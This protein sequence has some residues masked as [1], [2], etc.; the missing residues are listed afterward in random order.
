MKNETNKEIGLVSRSGICVDGDIRLRYD[1]PRTAGANL[2]V[3]IIIAFIAT[4]STAAMAD[5][6]VNA[7]NG[8]LTLFFLT[9]VSVI[10]IS[11]TASRYLVVRISAVIVF[12][13]HA[14]NILLNLSNARIGFDL[15]VYNYL[16]KANIP[17]GTWGTYAATADT[18]DPKYMFQLFALV[19]LIVAGG[20]ALACVAKTDFPIL[21][22]FTFPLFEIGLYQGFE[23][24]T[25]STLGLVCCWIVQL[26]LH[27]INHTTNK[28]GRRNTFAVHERSRTFYFT[29]KNEKAKFFPLYAASV[30]STCVAL[31][32]VLLIFSA[33]TGFIRPKSFDKLRVNLHNAI[34]RLDITNL[35][36]FLS[37]LSGGDTLHGQKTIGGTNGGHLGENNGISFNGSVCLNVTTPAFDGPLYL[38]G[39]VGSIYKNNSW[40]HISADDFPGTLYDAFED[41][42]YIPQDIDYMLM[43]Q[44]SLTAWQRQGIY[45][46]VK[47]A[48]RKF[49]YA[50]YYASY[51]DFGPGDSDYSIIGDGYVY[52]MNKDDN[53]TFSYYSL[54]ETGAETWID[55]E[56]ALLSTKEYY[57][58]SGQIYGDYSAYGNRLFSDYSDYVRRSYLGVKQGLP[59]LDEAYQEISR[60]VEGRSGNYTVVYNAIKDYFDENGFTYTTTPGAT[61]KGEDFINYFLGTQKKGYCSYY[62][63]AGVMLLRMFGFPARYT[64]G[65]MILPSQMDPEQMSG[66]YYDIRVSD[67]CA[68]AWAEVYLDGIGWVPAEFT[69][70]Y[71]SNNNPHL[72]EEEK[73]GE[74]KKTETTTT[75]TAA[76]KPDTGDGSKTETKATDGSGKATTKSTGGNGGGN[77][78]TTTTGTGGGSDGSGTGTGKTTQTTTTKTGAP[79]RG[80]K[81][82]PRWLKSALLTFAAMVIVLLILILNRSRRLAVKAKKCSQKDLDKRVMEIYRYT[83]R[84]IALLGVEVKRNITDLQNCEELIRKCHEKGIK[85]I[86]EH[87][88]SLTDIAVKAHMSGDRVTPEEAASA[89]ASMR[90]ISKKVV[91]PALS[92]LKKLSAMLLH[93]LY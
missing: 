38:R 67:R 71:V 14:V 48:D 11:L 58:G 81:H 6:F 57:S 64:E 69:P 46:E 24:P 54:S 44:S 41:A 13:I 39:Y 49:I 78:K 52:P 36:E 16:E 20:A 76:K 21:F 80:V 84:Y 66:G 70:G 50:P 55:K 37:D 65:Y 2:P 53:Y 12:L 42:G 79:I 5:S 25:W 59:A 92:P 19:I 35:D 40:V 32:L 89:A 86:G 75:T 56:S 83:L 15:A 3:R 93:C 45:I 31:F 22:I 8:F 74:K 4:L 82:L 73:A 85:G 61:P 28:A 1:K 26:S 90:Y 34:M 91:Y 72:T 7:H 60:R 62:A 87:L 77:K 43:E 17:A 51:T 9:A 88:S 68:H 27:I 18:S 63:S 30:A 23:A 33:V 29:S 47:N 10:S